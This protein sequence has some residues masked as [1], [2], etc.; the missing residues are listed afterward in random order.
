MDEI[1]LRSEITA[2]FTTFGSIVLFFLL[3]I[4]YRKYTDARKKDVS[5]R[6]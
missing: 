1:W 2:L 3:A 6:S 5:N 4:F